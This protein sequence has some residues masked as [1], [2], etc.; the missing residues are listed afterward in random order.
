[1]KTKERLERGGWEF[2]SYLSYLEVYVKGD[3]LLWLNPKND[4][5]EMVKVNGIYSIP[6]DDELEILC[7]K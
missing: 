2:D 1:M 7:D 6:T 4:K 3:S 5:V